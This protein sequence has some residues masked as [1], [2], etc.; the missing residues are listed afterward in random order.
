MNTMQ[1]VTHIAGERVE[2]VV[3]KAGTSQ[4]VPCRCVQIRVDGAVV[5]TSIVYGEAD[6]QVS[7]KRVEECQTLRLLS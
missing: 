1:N 3:G 5:H 6:P 4:G 2:V 7:T